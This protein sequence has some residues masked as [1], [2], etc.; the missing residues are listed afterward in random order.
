MARHDPLAAYQRKR[1]FTRT[2]EPAG[3]VGAVGARLC[4]VIH[5]H[6]ARTRRIL[7]ATDLAAESGYE[8]YCI[9]E[10]SGLGD[11]FFFA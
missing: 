11:S 2:P 9:T 4:Y 3:D 7:G 6:A 10:S 8:T 1:D 5:K